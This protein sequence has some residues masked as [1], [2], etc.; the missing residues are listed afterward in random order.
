MIEKDGRL[1]GIGNTIVKIGNINL[2]SKPDVKEGEQIVL[3]Q[4]PGVKSTKSETLCKYEATSTKIAGVNNMFAVAYILN[5]AFPSENNVGNTS[6]HSEVQEAYWAFSN[7]TTNKPALN[8]LAKE[9]LA[10][11]EYKERLQKDGGKYEPYYEIKDQKVAF[12][13]KNGKA[14]LGSFKIHY[15]RGFAK[16][17]GREKVEFGG[18]SS[19]TLYDQDGK[20][21]DP[22]TWTIT[23]DK[24]H[25]DSKQERPAGD[26][27][28]GAEGSD[29]FYCYPYS[30]EDFNIVIN[31]KGNENLRKISKILIKYFDTDYTAEFQELT[32]T[33]KEVNWE[34][35]SDTR[36][37]RG[38]TYTAGPNGSKIPHPCTH[39]KMQPHEV[40]VSVK[41]VAH[42]TVL[43]AQ[44]QV[45]INKTSSKRWEIETEAT[46]TQRNNPDFGTPN[47]PTTSITTWPNYPYWPSWPDYPDWPDW[48]DWPENPDLD[49]TIRLAGVVWEDT[50]TGK[51]SNY[52]GLI[53]YKNDGTPE[54]GI[55]NVKVTLYKYGTK[56]LASAKQNP[57][58]TDEKGAY[59]F[60]RVPMGKYDVEFEYDGMTYTTTKA[61]ANGSVQDYINNPDNTEYVKSAKTEETEEVRQNFNDKFYEITGDASKISTSGTS[62]GIARD[63][64]GN[65]TAELEYITE[66]GKSTLVTTDADGK[67]KPEFAM[68]VST[69]DMGIGYPFYERYVNDSTDIKI[70][71]NTYEANYKYMCYIN[72]GLKKR[73]QADFALMKD[74]STAT[75]TINKK[76]LNYKY[77]SRAGM[78]AFDITV[79][80]TPQY[81]NIRY[82]RDIYESDYNYRIDDYKNNTM[83]TVSGA[84]IRGLKTEDQELKV[85]VTYKI[86]IRNQSEIPA[87]TI[88]E[89]VDYYDKNYKLVEDD[90]RLDI[91]NADGTEEKGKVVARKSYYETTLGQTGTISWKST[92]KYDTNLQDGF[93]SIYTTDLENVILQTGEDINL[94]VTF[95][96][97][98]DANRF[99]KT[100]E[101]SN[102]VE[103]N[104]FSTFENGATT[105]DK[106]T[107]QVDR[108]SAPGNMQIYD[109]ATKEDDSDSAPTIDVKLA[110]GVKRTLNGVT[111]NDERTNTLRTGQKVGD[112]LMQDGE[113]KVNGVRVQLVE[114]VDSA[115]GK[116]YEY[117]WQE[118]FTGESAYKYVNSSGSV[119]DGSRGDVQAGTAQIS[120]GEYKFQDYI[121]GN[122]IVRFIYG[123]S[124]K[125]IDPNK[126]GGISYNGQDYKSTAYQQGNNLDNEWYNLSDDNLNNTRMSDAKDNQARRLAVMNYSKVMKYDIAKVL[127]SADEKNQRLYKELMDRT[128]MYADTAKLKVEVEYD[129]TEAS[130]L[131]NFNYDVRNIDFGLE[132]RPKSNMELSKDI[133]GIKLTLANGET[134][135]D[136]ENGIKKN[137]NWVKNTDARQGKIHIYMDQEIMQGANIEIKYRI[138]ATNHSEVDTTGA[139]DNSVGLTYYTGQYSASDRIVTTAVDRILDYVDS[140]LVFKTENNQAWQLIENTDLKSVEDMKRNGYLD[141]SLKL[142][143]IT[144][145]G[146]ELKEA[147]ISQIIETEALKGQAMTPGSSK[148]VDLVLTKTISAADDADDLSYDN[149]AEIIQFT[150]LVGRKDNIPGNQEPSEAPHEKDADYT[151]TVIITPPTGEN[152]AT[153]YLLIGAVVLVVLAGGIYFIRKKVINK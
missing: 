55:K 85:F 90:V 84:E 129:K 46:P 100:G 149:M 19:I 65:K 44:D 42:T 152:K 112:G 31:Q 88:N 135:I 28:Y 18:I 131:E 10:F 67:L 74:V 91:Q 73:T 21:L 30:D 49:L 63:R 124:E 117:I 7:K 27:D 96:V 150:N 8:G 101:K 36:T 140:S 103:I 102:Y 34:V 125:T 26:E 116:Q 22:K 37:C 122:Y 52:D 59:Y 107:G 4:N 144:T 132:E 82:N 32:G 62:Y 97:D 66:N 70:D 136:T 53:G 119:L 61:Y 148:S 23:Y 104:S 57:V 95:E 12:D 76:Q 24:E 50:Q 68:Q 81:S 114:L 151:E 75:V 72:L 14:I 133:V 45:Q 47:W 5:K 137:V 83:N 94:Y 142:V 86:T 64:A 9:A 113:N 115:D 121:P 87:G 138:T 1:T 3:R 89:L 98:K 17:D 109:N 54:D 56:E 134:I 33:Y 93:N 43:S 41:L 80:N 58:Y 25:Q 79:K 127:Y 143:K 146:S 11:Q 118:M 147:P 126:N 105:K 51:E 78:D 128:W 6:T 20:E 145:V 123:D 29:G 108:D 77:N 35:Q 92:G 130:G 106:T 38:G 13:S 99:I 141:S 139:S 16:E 120:K 39:G 69:S 71:D 15:Q 110:E 153:Y 48:P 60:T 40:E 111:W 2:G